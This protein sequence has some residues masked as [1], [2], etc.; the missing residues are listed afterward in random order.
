MLKYDTYI[1]EDT[2]Q[3]YYN[4]IHSSTSS[5]KQFNELHTQAD[6]LGIFCLQQRRNIV[7]HLSSWQRNVDA[8]TFSGN[9]NITWVIKKILISGKLFITEFPW[10][11]D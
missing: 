7:R 5:S 4:G 11:Y 1:R 6:R 8:L 2:M 3:Y 10:E 9:N